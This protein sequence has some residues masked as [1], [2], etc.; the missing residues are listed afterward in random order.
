MFPISLRHRW[1]IVSV[2]CCTL[3]AVGTSLYAKDAPK[4][5]A[6]EDQMEMMM[7]AAQPGEQH[8][9]MKKCAG[10]WKTVTKSWMAPGDP[11]ISEGTAEFKMI[12][13]DRFLEQR[14]T[15]NMMNMPYEG[16]GLTGYDNVK[17]VYTT[18]WIDNMNTSMMN[19]TGSYDA[20][21]KTMTFKASSPGP[22]GKMMN[23]RMTN[24]MTDDNTQIFTMYSVD[25]GKE[26]KMMEITYTRS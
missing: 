4:K 11:V 17:K 18:M 24:V 9:M 5:D 12:L 8:E 2:A 10:S 16:Y 15:G 3:A 6:R 26:M 20:A 1:I 13:G 25:K 14:F 23:M 7:K 19:G 22:D 21:K